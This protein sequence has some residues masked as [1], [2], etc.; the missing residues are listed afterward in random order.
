MRSQTTR[1]G[2]TTVYMPN[3]R[4]SATIDGGFGLAVSK[5]N[6]TDTLLRQPPVYEGGIRRTFYVEIALLVTTLTLATSIL[7]LIVLSYSLT[8]CCRIGV[9]NIQGIIHLSKLL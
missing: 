4:T 3:T 2:Y 9:T 1:Q 6:M 5:Q 8:H 7:L